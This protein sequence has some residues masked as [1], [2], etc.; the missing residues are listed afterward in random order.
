[1][2]LTFI[3][4]EEADLEKIVATYNQTVPGRMVTADTEPVS[5]ESK[6]NWFRAHNKTNRP[7]WIVK[8]DNVYAGWISFNSFYGRPAYDITAEVSIYLDENMRG[9][10]I[11]EKCLKHALSEAPQRGIENLLGFIFGHN[12]ASLKLFYKNGFEKWA[13]FPG[14]ALMDD[15]RRDLIILGK[16]V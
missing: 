3:Y 16:K 10:G 7:L 9:K 1:M 14:V 15:I 6:R 11:G 12:E 4:A 5:V 2:Q 8:A 13:H